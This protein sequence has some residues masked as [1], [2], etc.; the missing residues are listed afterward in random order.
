MTQYKMSSITG[1]LQSQVEVVKKKGLHFR[2][3]ERTVSGKREK[4]SIFIH[5]TIVQEKRISA[6]IWQDFSTCRASIWHSTNQKVI[7]IGR[8]DRSGLS[9]LN[10]Q[11]RGDNKDMFPYWSSKR[12]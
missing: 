9:N 11:M 3:C 6:S 7:G 5:R 2:R 1:A 10:R 8:H 4:K 12:G